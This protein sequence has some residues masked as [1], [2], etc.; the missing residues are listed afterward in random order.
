[1]EN[2]N[3]LSACWRVIKQPQAKLINSEKFAVSAA[4]EYRNVSVA[5]SIIFYRSGF[6][7]CFLSSL[8]T[9]SISVCVLVNLN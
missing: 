2:A 8:L 1:M 9:V 7:Y 6:P 3:C 4:T 5:V